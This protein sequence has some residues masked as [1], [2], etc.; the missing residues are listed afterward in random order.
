MLKA[1]KRWHDRQRHFELTRRFWQGYKAETTFLPP[2]ELQRR[3]IEHCAVCL[4][5]RIDGTS[6]VEYLP[7]EGK[8]EAVRQLGRHLLGERL[9]RWNE[10]LDMA[11]K[12]FPLCVQKD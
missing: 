2:E 1:I 12:L 10:V 8:R 4:L 7:E 6:P 11:E 3:C 9:G 5:A